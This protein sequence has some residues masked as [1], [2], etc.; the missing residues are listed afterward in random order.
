MKRKAE[1]VDIVSATPERWK[2]VVRLFGQKGACAGCWCTF[3]RL[4]QREYLEGR[5]A[6]NRARLGRLI[7][8]GG[9]PGL[10]ACVGGEPAAWCA[11]APREVYT[12]LARSRTLAPVDDR[13][14]WS[15]TCF[16]VARAHRRKGLTVRLLEAAC[17]HAAKHGARTV[18]GY[19][20][21]PRKGAI[22]DAFAYTGL[23]SAFREAGFVE[24]ARRSSWQP[25]MRRE[26]DAPPSRRRRAKPSKKAS[27]A[28]SPPSPRGRRI[29][30]R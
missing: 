16:F 9:E 23:V 26:L 8:S 17:A 13:P 4:T 28:A 24:A 29:S 2:D 15:V 7:R 20:V 5:G 10:I 30:L 22:P 19:P 25:I 11:V 18:E 3:W 6:K 14:V 1:L 27:H 21:E 12:R